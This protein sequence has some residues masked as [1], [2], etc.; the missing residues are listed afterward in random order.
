MDIVLGPIIH[1]LSV[2]FVIG[3]VGCLIS[4][5]IIALRF[6]AVLKERDDSAVTVREEQNRGA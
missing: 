4:I 2:L 5:P 1:A 3:W 6:A